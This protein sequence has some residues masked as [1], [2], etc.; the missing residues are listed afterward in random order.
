MIVRDFGKFH[1][2]G[3]FRMKKPYKYEF[4]KVEKP[5]K[6]KYFRTKELHK[7]EYL[8]VKR[9]NGNI[10]GRCGLKFLVIMDKLLK[11]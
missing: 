5:Y 4:S 7:Y 11:V 9:L 8:I 10:L 1:E 2:Y 3:H 6:Y